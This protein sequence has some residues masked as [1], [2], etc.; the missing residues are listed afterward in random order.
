M[1]ISR[2]IQYKKITHIETVTGD[3]L[4]PINKSLIISNDG[5][6]FREENNKRIQ[7]AT[8]VD[9]DG[10]LRISV[11]VRNKNGLQY[12]TTVGIHRLVGQYFVDGR[13]DERPVIDH[14]DTDKQNNWHE[15]LE[16][17]SVKENTVRAYNNKLFINLPGDESKN[18]KLTEE[19]VHNICKL[20]QKGF[21]DYYIAR[22]YNIN[23]QY[24]YT[25][26][27]KLAWKHISDQYIFKSSSGNQI[28]RPPEVYQ[29]V[30]ENAIQMDSPTIVQNVK[31]LFNYDLDTKYINR[32]R[33]KIIHKGEV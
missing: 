21:D 26:R 28:H 31:E 1:H 19:L 17:V 10:Y 27:K 9:T 30:R 29:Y 14:V 12:S 32:I 4:I 24:I 13:S 33:Y 7:I 16:W 22:K 5:R 11:R 3:I 8:F 15:N 18:H 20:L 6:V 25:I 23:R 2:R